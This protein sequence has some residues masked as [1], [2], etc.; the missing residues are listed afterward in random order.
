LIF[1]FLAIAKIREEKIEIKVFISV[2]LITLNTKP[3]GLGS[4][5][6]YSLNPFNPPPLNLAVSLRG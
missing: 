3:F 2:F 4:L 6:S 1:S 5:P